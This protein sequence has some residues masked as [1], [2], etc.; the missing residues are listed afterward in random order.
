MGIS[1]D[2]HPAVQVVCLA[3]GH[4]GGVQA[5][6]GDLRAAQRGREDAQ[7]QVSALQRALEGGPEADVGEGLERVQALGEGPESAQ[8]LALANTLATLQEQ[9][10]QMRW[11]AACYSRI[12]FAW[13]LL[14]QQ[15]GA[16]PPEQ[17]EQP[18]Q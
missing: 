16:R 7:V 1:S 2:M 5:L 14:M 3:Y 13:C 11:L 8:A 12:Y 17:P 6:Q 4:L 15:S 18:Q 10:Q 9:Q